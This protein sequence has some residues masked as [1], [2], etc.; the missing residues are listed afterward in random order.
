V[1]EGWALGVYIRESKK[2]NKKNGEVYFRHH[3]VEAVRTE[4]GPRQRVVMPL[5]QL[6]LPKSEWKKLAH[7]LECQLSN[8]VSTLLPQNANKKQ[9]ILSRVFEQI[10]DRS[11]PGGRN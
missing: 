4:K 1:L 8:Q 2:L 10:I 7:T 6:I 9:D 3:L 5:G 11:S